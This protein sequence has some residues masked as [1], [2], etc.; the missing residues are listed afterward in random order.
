MFKDR[1]TNIYSKIKMRKTKHL[2]CC[3]YCFYGPFLI[4][5][6]CF[7]PQLFSRKCVCFQC[8]Q[9]KSFTSAI[10]VF[11]ASQIKPFSSIL[12]DG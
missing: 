8:K 1:S 3:F 6:C 4:M 2:S 9:Q 11:G 7:F 10:Q 5:L 12:V